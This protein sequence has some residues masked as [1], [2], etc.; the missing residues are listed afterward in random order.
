MPSVLTY[1][2]HVVDIN[3]L[4]SSEEGFGISIIEAAGCKIPTIAAHS[5][6]MIEVVEDNITGVFFPDKNRQAL[7]QSMLCFVRNPDLQRH[8]GQQARINALEK[9][10]NTLYKQKTKS[11]FANAQ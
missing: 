3:I 5:S 2:Q 1:L 9:Y 8:M 4:A 6:G 7:I 11:V 10:N